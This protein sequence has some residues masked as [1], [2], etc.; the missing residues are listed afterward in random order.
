LKSRQISLVVPTFNEVSNVCRFDKKI[1]K[2][3]VDFD[4]ELIFVDDNSPDKTHEVVKELSFKNNKIRIIRRVGRRGL[5]GACLEGIACAKY[6]Y[7]LI[8]DADMQHDLAKIP[9]MY[10]L[11]LKGADLVIG[12]RYIHGDT[13][14]TS[15]DKK[16]GRM[17]LFATKLAQ[18]VCGLKLTDPMS[19]FFLIDRTKIDPH[20]ISVSKD[21]FKILFDIISKVKDLKIVEIAYK[22]SPRFSGESKL[23]SKVLMDFFVLLISN[24]LFKFLSPRAI[25]FCLIALLGLILHMI[26]ITVFVSFG[27]S[28]NISQLVTSIGVIL[29]NYTL[30]NIFT[31]RDVKLNGVNFLLGGVKFLAISLV[32]VISN[33]SFSNYLY[34]TQYKWL[35]SALCGAL[36][37]A[38]WNYYMSMTLVW[39][40]EGR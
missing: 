5:S 9:E 29:F 36:I 19:G 1:Q 30:N 33:L 2:I 13:D 35:I 37:G 17:S 38:T 15:F 34:N 14:F 23:D 32:G 22:F 31:Y 24:S 39:S 12:S 25:Y 8:T 18:F 3:L 20:L 4:Y 16:R 28:F 6:K 21:G 7:V 27:C 26:F 40:R 11:A 10:S